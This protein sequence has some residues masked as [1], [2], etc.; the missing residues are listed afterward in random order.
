MKDY[1]GRKDGFT[2]VEL[3]TVIAIMALLSALVLGLAGNAQKSAARKRAESETEQLASFVTEYL[4][5]YGRV[6]SSPE[7]LSNALVEANHH[8]TNM[9]D[10]WG[11]TYVY[12]N[13]SKQTF[14]LY[15]Y[16]GSETNP[17]VW[18]GQNKPGG[19]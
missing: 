9:L 4:S 1:R 2:L 14:Y 12:S 15:S 10:P 5:E 11:M 6:P 8:L 18:I 16:G 13:T 17:A 3:M 19:D 7:A